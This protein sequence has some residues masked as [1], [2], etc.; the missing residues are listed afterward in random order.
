MIKQTVLPFK[1]ETTKDLLT[2]HAGL[3]LLGEFAMGLGLNEAV[4]RHLLD[5]GSRV[6]SLAS[7]HVFPHSFPGKTIS[8]QQIMIVFSKKLD[9]HFFMRY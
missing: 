1:F 3:A 8:Y 2:S 7:E 6:G 5:P 9:K 4:D